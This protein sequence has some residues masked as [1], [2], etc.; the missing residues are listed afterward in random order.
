MP[1]VILRVRHNNFN[2]SIKSKMDNERR[3][4]IVIPKDSLHVLNF[5]P[6]PL[7]WL[8][9]GNLIQLSTVIKMILY[10]PQSKEY[11]EVLFHTLY[12]AFSYHHLLECLFY[13]MI[14][15]GMRKSVEIYFISGHFLVQSAN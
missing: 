6:F 2:T 3:F 1:K 15:Y 9:N 13:N 11:T 14:A 4:G 5:F 8:I 10:L 7:Q 12:G